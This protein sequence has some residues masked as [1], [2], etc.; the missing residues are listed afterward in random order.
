MAK[1]PDSSYIAFVDT[2][3]SVGHKG[4]LLSLLMLIGSIVVGKFF[5]IPMMQR[6][7]VT[8]VCATATFDSM[9]PSSDSHYSLVFITLLVAYFVFY[10]SH[11][12]LGDRFAGFELLKGRSKRRGE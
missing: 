9:A 12:F 1:I 3:I 2:L 7:S 10:Q 8:L 6:I 11:M 4:V 5:Y